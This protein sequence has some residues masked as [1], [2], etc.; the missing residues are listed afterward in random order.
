[1]AEAVP[2]LRMTASGGGLVTVI[3]N[4]AGDLDPTVGVI[5]FSGQL[6]SGCQTCDYWLANL[7]IGSTYPVLGSAAY[8]FLDIASINVSNSSAGTMLIEFTND[9]NVDAPI[10][11]RGDYSGTSGGVITYGLFGGLSAF[12]TSQTV[13]NGVAAAAAGPYSGSFQNATFDPTTL[14]GFNPANNVWLTQRIQIAHAKKGG[15][16]SDGNFSAQVP[17][18]TTL[19]LLGAG[20]AGLGLLKRRSS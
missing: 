15:E 17:E 6:G 10:V 4:G 5:Q 13:F 7:T 12:S 11:M 1:M 19:L 9:F 2:V 18:P 14:V 20:L 16:K 8:P 3:D